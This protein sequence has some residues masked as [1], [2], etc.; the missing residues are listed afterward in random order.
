[1]KRYALLFLFLTGCNNGGNETIDLYN[2]KALFKNSEAEEIIIPILKEDIRAIEK[3]MLS[4]SNLA[5][6]QEPKYGS[7]LV[8]FAIR[9]RKCESLKKLLKFGADPDLKDVYG[10]TPLFE[11]IYTAKSFNSDLRKCI[12]YL[13][14]NGADPNAENASEMEKAKDSILEK[15]TSLLMLASSR[16]YDVSKLLIE[17]G[18]N[19]DYK[20][21]SNRTSAVISLLTKNVETAHLLI[22]ENRAKVTE[23]FSANL[24]LNNSSNGLENSNLNKTMNRELFPI[25]LLSN[26]IFPIGSDKHLLKMEIVKEF[27]RQGLDYFGREIPNRTVEQIEQLYPKTWK[28]YLKKY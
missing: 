24:L 13:L 15:G 21:K 11:A 7:S 10:E 12:V 18:A 25:D 1:M 6:Y 8:H 27:E 17:Y 28:D 16:S 14:E 4:N 9:K 20:T 5:T 3:L 26:W 22:V 19:I 2:S 23:S